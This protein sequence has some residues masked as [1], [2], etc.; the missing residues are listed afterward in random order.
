MRVVILIAVGITL[1]AILISGCIE[2]KGA[3]NHPP[4]ADFTWLPENPNANQTINF[5]SN[6]SDPDGDELLY[7]WNFGDGTS[8]S[9]DENPVH[10]YT[11]AGLY[12]VTLTVNDGKKSSNISKEIDI[13]IATSN[14]PPIANFSYTVE[15]LTVY[16]TDESI[17]QDGNISTWSW[18]FGDLNTSTEANPT[19]VYSSHGIYNV[20]LMV[21]DD[22]SS[23]PKSDI[24]VKQ[25]TI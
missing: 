17:D 20:T 3:S 7:T 13:G 4:V 15:N 18:D 22:D 21:T 9:S 6:S 1:P 2:E 16:F 24:I 23:D 19:H 25:I 11:E 5:R 10:V 14:L 12:T 8:L